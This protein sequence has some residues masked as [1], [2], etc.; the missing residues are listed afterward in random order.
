MLN[1]YNYNTIFNKNNTS[2]TIIPFEK[3]EQMKFSSLLTYLYMIL[4]IFIFSFIIFAIT[5]FSILWVVFL[6]NKDIINLFRYFTFE[7]FIQILCLGMLCIFVYITAQSQIIAFKSVF[8]T[9]KAHKLDL[10][11]VQCFVFISI[12]LAIICVYLFA[13]YVFIL[14]DLDALISSIQQYIKYFIILLLCMSVFGVI[15]SQY[16]LFMYNH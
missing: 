1:Q 15:L 10:L 9:Y 4:Q 2:E 5:I 11:I 6:I 16:I 14:Y 8:A 12:G 7:S 3:R 13:L